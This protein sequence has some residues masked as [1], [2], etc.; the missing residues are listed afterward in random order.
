MENEV[1]KFL[2]AML[3]IFCHFLIFILFSV[4]GFEISQ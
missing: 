1:L 2:L 4:V 3:T